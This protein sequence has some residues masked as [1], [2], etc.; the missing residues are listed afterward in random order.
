MNRDCEY[1]L[2]HAPARF[3]PA[4]VPEETSLLSRALLLIGFTLFGLAAGS[5]VSQSLWAGYN[6]GQGP[7]L[8]EKHFSIEILDRSERKK[9]PPAKDDLDQIVQAPAIQVTVQ[10]P[11]FP[12]SEQLE[13]NISTEDVLTSYGQPHLTF[14]FLEHGQ[15]IQRF[16]YIDPDLRSTAILFR[17]GLLVGATAPSVHANN[18]P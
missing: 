10:E 7:S 4:T 17:E 11:L 3:V 1:R 2:S 8:V 5:W 13:P 15:T 16:E 14:T 12:V 9:S 18:H 6:K